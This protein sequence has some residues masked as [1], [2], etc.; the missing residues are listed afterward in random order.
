MALYVCPASETILIYFIISHTAG[1]A[2]PEEALTAFLDTNWIHPKDGVVPPFFS[3][4]SGSWADSSPMPSAK[5]KQD[6]F[7]SCFAFRMRG[8]DEDPRE[9]HE[10]AS[11]RRSLKGPMPSAKK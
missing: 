1:N 9:G 10:K 5:V 4:V 11:R 8:W 7:A 6:A 3:R 2:N